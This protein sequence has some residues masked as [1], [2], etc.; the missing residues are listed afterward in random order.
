MIPSLCFSHFY[1]SY[2]NYRDFVTVRVLYNC[3]SPN[4]CCRKM[5]INVCLNVLFKLPPLIPVMLKAQFSSKWC[6]DLIGKRVRYLTQM[7][8]N[9]YLH[10]NWKTKNQSTLTCI[11]HTG[12]S[13]WCKIKPRLKPLKILT[14]SLTTSL[15]YRQLGFIYNGR[16]SNKMTWYD[17][18][19]H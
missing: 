15:T 13:C 16:Y 10:G 3:R 8:N 1:V 19:E 6:I 7:F 11:P 5:N 4:V 12:C 9:A 18:G 14:T 2:I 17:P